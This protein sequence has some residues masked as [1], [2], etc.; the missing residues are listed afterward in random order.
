M[1]AG[2]VFR[3][4]ALSLSFVPTC[5]APPPGMGTVVGGPSG[6]DAHC[7]SHASDRDKLWR[8]RVL[9]NRP[10][11]CRS[12]NSITSVS[13]SLS[14]SVHLLCHS[15]SQPQA[16]RLYLGSSSHRIL[17][18]LIANDRRRTQQALRICQRSAQTVA[19][20]H[21]CKPLMPH[22]KEDGHLRATAP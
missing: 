11:F 16:D 14:L 18:L 13:L 1:E 5:R 9:Q 3:G 8:L 15:R 21:L 6:L 20:Y 12:D 4:L 7:M 2:R 10:A 22:E 19:P 17:D